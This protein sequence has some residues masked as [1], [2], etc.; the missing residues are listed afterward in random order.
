MSGFPYL[1]DEISAFFI[2]EGVTR[3][4]NLDLH[5]SSLNK[6]SQ[7]MLLITLILSYSNCLSALCMI[8]LALLVFIVRFK[9]NT[10]WN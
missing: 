5:L 6:L 7:R 3:D 9:F 1:V 10:N 8:C 2:V 4:A